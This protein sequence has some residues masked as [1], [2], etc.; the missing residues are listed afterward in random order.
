MPK[1]VPT[2][3]SSRGELDRRVNSR[4][5]A[6]W[7]LQHPL[8]P[9]LLLFALT[10]VVF[11]PVA[12]F[13]FV[14]YDD[15]D[16]VSA[17]AHVQTGLSAAN[18]IWA[19][20]SGH[21]SNWHP[22]T[23]L[24]HQL[25][26]TLFGLKPGPQH[27]VNVVFHA[28]NA[29]L[30]FLVLRRMTG[31]H[32]PSALVAALFAVHPLRVESVAWISERKDVLSGL[33]LLLTLG[34]YVR[35]AQ[36]RTAAAAP[37]AITLAW[38]SLSLICFGLGLLSKPMLV[39]AP[40][41]LL[42]LD[43]WPLGRL[44]LRQRLLPQARQRLLEKLPFLALAI[45]SCAVTFLVQRGGGAVSTSLPVGARIANAL[46]SYVRYLSKTFWPADLSVL[47]PHPGRWPAL[48]VAGAGALLAFAST[49]VILQARTRPY[50]LVGW[51]W[52]LGALVPVIGLIQVGVQAMADRYS[53]VPS[54]GLFI[55]L[56][57]SAQDV[58]YQWPRLKS[59]AALASLLL[60]AAT[61]LACSHQLQFWRD[62]G[63]L[64][65]RAV[66]VTS[67]NYLAYNN[68]G[69]FLSGQGR[70]D[71]AEENYRKSLAINP[72]YSDALNNL[73]FALAGQG[74]P[75]EAIPLYEAALRTSPRQPE[76]HNNL[77]N[78]L[79]EM[80]RLDEA[81]RQYLL[82]LQQQPDHPEAHNN[83]GIALAM[84]GK[85]DAAMEQFRTAIGLKPG[86]GDAYSNFGNALAA[87]HKFS[88]ALVQYEQALRRSP[89][90][91]RA[92]NNLGN[93]LLEL[94]EPQEAADHYIAALRLKADNPEACFGL[95]VALARLN[96]RAE[97][98]A[99]FRQALRL[100]PSHA[101]AQR[102]LELLSQGK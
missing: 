84:Q 61:G 42:L 44:D 45:G 8:A 54:I 59:G 92:H 32:W 34:A 22:L 55:L 63:A 1:P 18:V 98:M 71:L 25:D 73:G 85:L 23:W 10:L 14:N 30:L 26:A 5:P 40:C 88:E 53:Y 29:V 50:L 74:K 101:E 39:T 94:G 58:L 43:Y 95:G 78:A 3:A 99:Q 79:S 6:R 31:A 52:F 19:F 15:P 51:F 65:R 76:I 87:Q 33:F 27:L 17:N 11:L 70:L 21:A 68:L 91:C 48:A 83:L 96:R 47:Y 89:G 2:Q 77:G 60:L 80:G 66:Q 67:N 82:A 46:V 100:N 49:M 64:F 12:H 38:Y 62:S 28:F 90:D 56:V 7:S 41:L 37:R 13:D 93:V 35:Y 16:Y 24:S 97:A 75:A 20:G 4:R 57:W 81:I 36:G 9:C 69:Y 72:T 102:Q 86:Y